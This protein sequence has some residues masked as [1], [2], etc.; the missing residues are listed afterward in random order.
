MS[1]DKIQTLLAKAA[2]L[3]QDLTVQKARCKQAKRGRFTG[4][5]ASEVSA[6]AG[7]AFV[8]AFKAGVVVSWTHGHGFLLRKARLGCPTCVCDSKCPCEHAQRPACVWRSVTL[9]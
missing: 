3:L 6:C 2:T 8:F 4:L 5:P 1:M 7:L 9:L